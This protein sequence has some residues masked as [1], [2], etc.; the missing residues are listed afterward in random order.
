MRRAAA[1]RSDMLDLLIKGGL[2][3]DG[4]AN[5]GFFGAIGVEGDTVTVL[6]GDMSDVAAERTLDARGRVVCPGFI[7]V[8]AHSALMILADP[9]HE[10]KVQQ[11]VTTELIGIDGN[12][13]APFK[14]REDLMSMIDLNSGLEGRPELP[15]TWLSV[16]E[17]LSMFDRKVAVNIAYILGNSPVRIWGVGWRDR[18]ATGPE[19]EDMKSVIR[20][21]MEEGAFGMSTGLDYPP[22]SYA[23]TDELVE[24]S[25]EVA[26]LGGIYH[27]HV[28]YQMG[29]KYLDPFKEAIEIGRR[30]GVPVHLTH[31][32]SRE[33][34]TGGA[35]RLLG[36]VEDGRAEGLD[37]TFDCFPYAYGGTRIIIA[38]PHWAQDGGPEKL[39]E[40]LRSPEMRER[41]RREVQPRARN[42]MD[43][44]LT[45]FKQPHNLKYTGKSV[46]EVAE[47]RGQHPVDALCDLLLDEDLQ[48]SY[49][50][51][52]IDPTTVADFVTHPLQMTGS[53]A[54]LL[55]D[56]PTLM[57]YGAFPTI[58]GQIVREERRM[59]LPEAIRKLTSYP[60]QRL[61]IPDRG[62]LRDGMKADVVVFDPDTIQANADRLEPRQLPSGIDYVIVN[63]RVV[64]DHGNHTGAL[65]GRALRHGRAS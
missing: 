48:V 1:E 12:S 8:H 43:A 45:Y 59:S 39:K 58:L 25:T 35:R 46:A 40:R 26:R 23:D 11:G 24:L 53:D 30:S 54:L 20:E 38:F 34:Q 4:S 49:W 51:A 18:P 65:A 27:T 22:G 7:D 52:I 36:L 5:P 9:A 47:M 33:T 63:G 61:G 2:I 29:D 62:L 42:W 16:S 41:F 44:W 28:R 3:I 32:F 17:Y 21:S 13:Y 6:R 60:A 15:A 31:M 56:Y 10:P 50:G 37:V 55:G 14:T 64:V 19:L 57:A